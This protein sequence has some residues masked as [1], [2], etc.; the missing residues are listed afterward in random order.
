[1]I[2]SL[3]LILEVMLIGFEISTDTAAELYRL[4]QASC[5]SDM[6]FLIIPVW[7]IC[8]SWID[9]FDGARWL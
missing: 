2:S 4:K 6:R 3:S 8:N 5:S 7:G 1:M 9:P